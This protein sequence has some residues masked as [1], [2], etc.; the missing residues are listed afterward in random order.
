MRVYMAYSRE[1]GA[2][3]VAILVFAH[4][5]QEAKS[6]A[7]G[8]FS[9]FGIT[10]EYI[11]VA[12]RWLKGKDFLFKQANQDYL[13]DDI[14]HIIDDPVSCKNCGFWGYELDDGGYCA[15]CQSEIKES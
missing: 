4:T 10:E 11:D 8:V 7:W 9:D 1:G 3:G 2:S 15:D 13:N 14:A 12:A 5:V 6:L